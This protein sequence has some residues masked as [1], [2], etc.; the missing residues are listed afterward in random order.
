MLI[1]ELFGIGGTPLMLSHLLMV[2]QDGFLA[3]RLQC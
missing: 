3:K 2:V 1:L